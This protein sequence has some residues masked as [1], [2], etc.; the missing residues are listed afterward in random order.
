MDE[1]LD[2]PRPTAE[3]IERLRQHLRVT[4]PILALYDCAP[5]PAFEPLVEPKDTDC[6]FSFFG[7]WLAG[8]TLIL[9]K[10]GPGCPGG[11][12][13][14]GLETRTPPFMAHFLSDGVG[15]PAGEGLRVNAHVAQALL[16]QAK[17][18]RNDSGH[19]LIGPLRLDQWDEVRSLTFLVDPDRVSGLATLAGYWSSTRDIVVAPFGSGCSSLLRALGGYEDIDP[20]VLGGLDVAM[21]QFMP[22]NL[23]TLTVS[24]A[25]FSKMLTFPDD[26][27]VFKPWW[28]ELMRQ[29]K[30]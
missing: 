5:S 10:G 21:R 23:V 4:A 3:A 28:T 9:K 29:R 27:F 26:S 14:L 8:E 30:A 15:A 24:P 25:R 18:V 20:A 7:R 2:G 17:P 16:D 6:C 13:A 11:H 12:R 22:D 1:Q 19:V